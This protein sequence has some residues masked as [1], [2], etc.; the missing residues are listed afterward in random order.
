MSDGLGGFDFPGGADGMANQKDNTT[1][2]YKR[3]YVWL[4]PVLVLIGTLLYA[5][6]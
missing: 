2:W 3:W 1:R 5:Y 6:N 4:L